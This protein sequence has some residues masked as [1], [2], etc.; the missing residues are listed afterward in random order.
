[1]WRLGTARPASAA[2]AAA[3][4]LLLRHDRDR[5]EKTDQKYKLPHG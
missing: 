2:R 5:R 3:L 4:R 1:M